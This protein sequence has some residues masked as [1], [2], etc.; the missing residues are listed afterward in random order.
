MT[1]L[2]LQ[3]TNPDWLVDLDCSCTFF[4]DTVISS[5]KEPISL[6]IG[7]IV[8]SW[9]GSTW[10]SYNITKPGKLSSIPDMPNRFIM[11]KYFPSDKPPLYSAAEI[12]KYRFGIE[13][14][15][16]PNSKYKVSYVPIVS[17]M[18]GNKESSP[19][20]FFSDLRN[21]V[22][23][24]L[25]SEKYNSIDQ[26]SRLISNSIR[27]WKGLLKKKVILFKYELDNNSLSII[28]F[29]NFPEQ[30]LISHFSYNEKRC[31][32]GGY[33]LDPEFLEKVYEFNGG[34]DGINKIISELKAKFSENHKTR[35]SIMKEF[36]AKAE[37]YSVP[38]L[39][40]QEYLSAKNIIPIQP[41][42]LDPYFLPD[43]N[44]SDFNAIVIN[45]GANQEGNTWHQ[46]DYGANPE[47]IKGGRKYYPNKDWQF[48]VIVDT[49]GNIWRYMPIPD[50][51][52]A[53][54][55]G[56]DYEVCGPHVYR[57]KPLKDKS[58]FDFK[59]KKIRIGRAFFTTELLMCRFSAEIRF[60]SYSYMEYKIEDHGESSWE[61]IYKNG[62]LHKN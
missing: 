44:M 45:P 9:N 13:F 58:Y 46:V 21:D 15:R 6:L 24:A 2:K 3:L 19:T 62:K 49:S 4:D 22:E 35:L 25:L 52:R 30:G 51:V 55:I 7:N 20:S 50:W 12:D 39:T 41:N 31:G 5:S 34:S 26:I 56:Q 16:L 59:Q 17:L 43:W 37:K 23:L 57:Y 28:N 14:N 61:K 29:F 1:Q 18:K 32:Y 48:S 53:S 10:S 60:D 36:E 11:S 8:L 33:E 27:L 40:Q 38:L 42:N 47:I 54:Y